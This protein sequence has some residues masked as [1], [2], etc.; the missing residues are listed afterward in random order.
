VETLVVVLL[1]HHHEVRLDNR[2]WK[3][4]ARDLV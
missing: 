4:L 3:G 2:I 1:A